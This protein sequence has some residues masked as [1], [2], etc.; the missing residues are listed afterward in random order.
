MSYPGIN[1]QIAACWRPIMSVTRRVANGWFLC[2]LCTSCATVG[3]FSHLTCIVHLRTLVIY[4]PETT[5]KTFII[6]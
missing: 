3:K 5:T 6:T 4:F 1:G 2:Q